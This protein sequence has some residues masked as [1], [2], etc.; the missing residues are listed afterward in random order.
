MP[1]SRSAKKSLRK[2]IKNRKSNVSIKN[3]FKDI[4]KKFLEKPSAEKIGQVQSMLD[5]AEKKGILH[6]NKVS[7]MKSQM[8]KKIGKEVVK[9][10]IKKAAKKKVVKKVAKKMS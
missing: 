8:S 5:K 2:S 10:V 6:K 3:K 7:R 1:I 9:V 4:V